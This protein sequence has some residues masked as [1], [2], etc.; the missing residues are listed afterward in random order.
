MDGYIGEI[1][2]FPYKYVPQGWLP[3]VG[4]ALPVQAYQALATVIGGLY[5]T[6]S[7]TTFYLPNL[8]A[9]TAID[10]GTGPG[11]TPRVVGKTTGGTESVTLTT[12]QMARHSHMLNG[13]FEND[14]NQAISAAPTAGASWFTFP[15]TDGASSGLSS[16]AYLTDGSQPNTTLAAGAVAITGGG[17]AHENRQPYLAFGYFICNDGVYPIKP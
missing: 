16:N 10:G 13:S 4:Q 15:Q 14:P 9:S 12:G 3:C 6:L 2:L 5:G 11:L 8:Q 17:A 7:Q 1:R